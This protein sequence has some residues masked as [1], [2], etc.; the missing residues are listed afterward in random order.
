[1]TLVVPVLPF[2]WTVSTQ[3]DKMDLCPPNAIFRNVSVLVPD[4]DEI[5]IIIMVIMII[6]IIMTIFR[7]QLLEV[8]IENT[9]A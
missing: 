5:M 7:K 3:F 4:A 1:M 2:Q 8:D 9:K 6:M